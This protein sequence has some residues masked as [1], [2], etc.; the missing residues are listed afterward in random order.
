MAKDPDSDGLLV[1]L[2]PQ[3]MT[4]PT[5]TAQQLIPYLSGTDK[6]ILASWMGG[7]DVATGERILSEAGVATFPYPD[8]AAHM[9]TELVHYSE[10]LKS[11]YETPGLTPD[12]VRRPQ[13]DRARQLIDAGPRPGPHDA[14]RAGVQ[15]APRRLRHP[16]GG[17]A[18]RGQRGGGRRGGRCHRLPGRRQARVTHHH[19][20][21]GRRRRAPGPAR[22]GRGP[23]CLR[24]HRAGRGRQARAGPLRGR[25]RAAHDRRGTATSSSSAAAWTP[26]WGPSCSS[27]WVASWWRSSR[28]ARWAC[29]R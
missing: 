24:G 13:R 3:A 11:L 7:N 10:N 8:S 21:V 22:R 9:F 18:H 20:Q 5:K 25:L 6:P 23:R 12:W 14:L 29:R 1:I 17:D 19:A 15:G 16:G 26:R 4:D 2:T 27:A 28:T